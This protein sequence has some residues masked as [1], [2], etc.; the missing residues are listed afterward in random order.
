MKKQP[1]LHLETSAPLP[2]L[3]STPQAAAPASGAWPVL[4]FLHGYD[5]AAPLKAKTALTRH[6]PLRPGNPGTAVEDFVV[7]A[8]Q[9]R[10]PGDS[11]HKHAATIQ[12]IVQAVQARYGGDP[13][14]T[15]LTGFS[16]GGNGVFDL[17][18]RLPELW[19][20]LWAVDPT[21]VPEK[22]PQLPTWLSSGEVSRRRRTSFVERLH[23]QE[24]DDVAGDISGD[25]IYFDRGL[26]HVATT[27]AAYRD[28]QIYAW[29]L[30]KRRPA[31]GAEAG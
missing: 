26:K 4:C 3:V 31:S 13:Q 27:T 25:R 1:N 9:L 5:E 18:L 30:A 24:P 10:A 22:D 11:W 12:Q 21:R 15:Y 17:A 14:R 16:F 23:L 29:L 2:Y 19:A 8:P 7:V 20:A 28:A 6:G